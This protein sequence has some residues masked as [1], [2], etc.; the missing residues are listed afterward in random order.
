MYDTLMYDKKQQLH[1]ENRRC[2][3]KWMQTTFQ[4]PSLRVFPCSVTVGTAVTKAALAAETVMS[5]L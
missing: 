2:H 1:D 5:V 4:R 3:L